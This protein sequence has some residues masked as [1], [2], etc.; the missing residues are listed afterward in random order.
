MKVYYYRWYWNQI[1]WKHPKLSFS[2]RLLRAI[3]HVIGSEIRRNRDLGT[4]PFVLSSSG[5]Q[6][7]TSIVCSG[8]LFNDVAGLKS[9]CCSVA[10]SCNRRVLFLPF[11]SYFL[12]LVVVKKRL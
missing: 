2:A 1:V 11:R 7:I 5:G 9:S 4:R 10:K 6:V 3:R 12:F 8:A